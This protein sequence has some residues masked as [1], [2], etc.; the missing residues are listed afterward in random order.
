[1]HAVRIIEAPYLQIDVLASS[2]RTTWLRTPTTWDRS[3]VEQWAHHRIISPPI[4]IVIVI[5][6]ANSI[7]IVISCASRKK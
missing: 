2:S 1:L 5:F 6:F 7:V 3:L 4:V